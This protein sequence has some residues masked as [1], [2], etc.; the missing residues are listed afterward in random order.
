VSASV[1]TAS[2]LKACLFDFGGTLDADGITWQDQFFALYRKHGMHPDRE[3]FRRAFYRSDD[4]LTETR[5]LEGVGFRETVAIQARGVWAALDLKEPEEKLQAVVEDFIENA[6]RHVRRNQK[7]LTA[8]KRSYRLGI[9]SNFY[10][11][12]EIVCDDLG[13]RNLFDCLID[14]NREGVTKPDPRI[15]QAALEK[16]GV[17]AEQ[18]VFVGDNVF[19]DM[20]GAREAGM[21]HVLVAGDRFA[22]RRSCCPHDPVIRTL[23]HLG[24]L[25]ENGRG[26]RADGTTTRT[27]IG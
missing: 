16:I 25:L 22:D 11:N 23:E 4:T 14:S 5:A 20:E 17:P 1:W 6:R 7:V 15:F 12:L 27:G 24:P 3:A 26:P 18:T 2:N 8:L 10:G 19:R 13:I 21:R 9:V